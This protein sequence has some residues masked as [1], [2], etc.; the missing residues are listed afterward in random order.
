MAVYCWIES[1]V[2]CPLL[3]KI[4]S[5]VVDYPRGVVCLL[6]AVF[7]CSHR[8]VP[9]VWYLSGGVSSLTLPVSPLPPSPTR[10]RCGGNPL[11]LCTGGI[12][13]PLCPVTTR[14]RDPGSTVLATAPGCP[15]Q[16]PR[17]ICSSPRCQRDSQAK[18]V[19]GPMATSINQSL[20]QSLQI[21]PCHTPSPPSTSLPLPSSKPI[22]S[23]SLASPH[24]TLGS[25]W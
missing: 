25:S 20:N 23:L 14:S 7:S 16:P 5:V 21:L 15:W 2:S 6:S 13:T 18:L 22:P 3:S 24:L 17:P 19:S 12:V 10:I 4:E 11:P 1:P 9:S 8:E